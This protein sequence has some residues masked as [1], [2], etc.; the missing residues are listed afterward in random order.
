VSIATVSRALN[1]HPE[2]GEKT[3]LRVLEAARE[4]GYRPAAAA[5]TLVT[6]RSQILGVVLDTGAGHPALQHPFFQH[7]LVGFQAEAAAHDFDLLLFSRDRTTADAE[8]LL[9]RCRQHQLDGVAVIALDLTAPALDALQLPGIP[10][11]ALDIDVDPAT[12]G[13]VCSDNVPGAGLAVRH[14]HELGHTRI[15]IIAGD[16]GTR[17][18]RERFE[19]FT[20]EMQ[21]LGLPIRDEY[22]RGGDFYADSGY[23]EMSALLALSEPPTAVFT[24]TDLMAAGALRAARVA[25]VSVPGDV[26]IS[27]YDGLDLTTLTHPQITTVKQDKRG[28]G[29]AAAQALMAMLGGDAESPP[30]ITL[31]VELVVREST[32]GDHAPP[33]VDG[34]DAYDLTVSEQDPTEPTPA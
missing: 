1:G 17:P 26:A 30:Q 6:R 15:A 19:G 33:H 25:G 34:A 11:V 31:P 8:S 23:D 9:A 22:V 2:V 3:R 27:G 10:C 16:R 12:T 5:R 7:V 29:V 14:L 18:G 21:R 28:L 4:I 20:K 32:A 24:A 13:L